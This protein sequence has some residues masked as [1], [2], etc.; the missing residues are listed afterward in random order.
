MST[1]AA[2]NPQVNLKLSHPKKDLR[3]T[4]QVGAKIIDCSG[5]TII[6]GFVDAHTHPVFAGDR[7]NEFGMKLVPC[8]HD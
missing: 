1:P 2:N 3:L 8:E 4:P 6:P 5:K 7:S